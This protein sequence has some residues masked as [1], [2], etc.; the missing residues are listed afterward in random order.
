M[1]GLQRD[2]ELNR[3][4]IRVRDDA[5]ILVL[6]NGVRIDLGYDQRNVVFVT[7]FRGVIDDHTPGSGRLRRIDAGH[8]GAGREQPDVRLAQIDAL[9]IP[10]VNGTTFE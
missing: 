8:F 3:G 7:K 10:A 6:S 5:A 9:D 4:A 1:D 2:H